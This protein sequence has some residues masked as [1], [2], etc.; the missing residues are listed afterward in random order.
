MQISIP[1]STLVETL[2]PSRVEG[3][4]AQTHISGFATLREAQA[5]DLSFLGSSKFS[6]QISE[7]KAMVVLVE[8]GVEVMPRDGQLLLWVKRASLAMARLCEEVAQAMWVRPAAG[9]HLSACIDASA[10]VDASASIGPFCVVEAGATVGP[11]SVLGPGC[12]VGADSSIGEDC[13]LGSNVTLE[14]D[15]VLGKRVRI[16]SGS[17]LGSEGFGYEFAQGR[18]QKI[19]QIG[20]VHVGD[21]VEI[22]SNTTI[23]RGRFGPTVIGEGT[24]IDNL[25]QIAHNVVI[26]KHCILCSQVGLSGSTNLGD[27]VVMGGRS[28]SAGH[29]SIGSGSQLAGV[30]VAYSDLEPN[31]KW[32][33]AP[34]IPLIAHQ[35]IMVLTQRLPEFFKRLARVEEQLLLPGKE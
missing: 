23:D 10:Q 11:R 27:Y 3:A 30:A 21:D 29:L 16:H 14:R 35:R 2:A 33:G 32:G 6:D 12:V 9:I 18:H 19:P 20:S 34:A 5:G 13:W 17:V 25:V 7:T 28:A 4:A 31:K 26:G 1:V 15:T 24:K 8:E 22:G